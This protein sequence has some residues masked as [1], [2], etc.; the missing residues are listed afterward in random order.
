LAGKVAASLNLPE[1][2]EVLT[3]EY[4]EFV[5]VAFISTMNVTLYSVREKRVLFDKSLN[6]EQLYENLVLVLKN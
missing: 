4:V 3:P 5:S 1:S 6:P 2:F